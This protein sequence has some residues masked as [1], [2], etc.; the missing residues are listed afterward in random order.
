MLTFGSTGI[1]FSH[2]GNYMAVMERKDCKDHVSLFA[3][4]SWQ[5][6]KVSRDAIALV[7]S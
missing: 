2:D 6:V 1:A 3:V 7:Q 5:L 4:S